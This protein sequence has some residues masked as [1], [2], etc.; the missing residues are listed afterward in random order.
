MWRFLLPLALGTPPVKT[1]RLS[2]TRFTT[3]LDLLK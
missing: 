1:D 2:G 3:Q